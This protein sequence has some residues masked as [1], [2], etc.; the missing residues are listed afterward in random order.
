MDDGTAKGIVEVRW[1]VGG[2]RRLAVAG[3]RGLPS[4]ALPNEKAILTNTPTLPDP[5]AMGKI[6][7]G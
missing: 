7:E 3:L 4:G 2:W 1:A 5:W 6:S